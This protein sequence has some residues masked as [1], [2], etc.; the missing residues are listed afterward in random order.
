M[1]CTPTIPAC[2]VMVASPVKE[3]PRGKRGV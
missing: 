2:G 1:L 3:S